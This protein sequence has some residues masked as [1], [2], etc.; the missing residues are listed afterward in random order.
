MVTEEEV[1][2]YL[3]QAYYISR[4]IRS[5]QDKCAELRAKALQQTSQWS[6][7]PSGGHSTTSP[8]AVWI[9]KLV[10]LELEIQNKTA[11]LIQAERDAFSLINLLSDHREKAV[12]E[13][14]H[15]NRLN[16]AKLSMKYDYSE[17][18]ILR[19]KN[20]GYRHLAKLI[21]EDASLENKIRMTLIPQAKR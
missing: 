20:K 18:Q 19:I 9:E 1:R 3:S 12:L 11:N 15:V 13:D 6:D 2:E 10:L 14:F 17:S 5:Q 16:N 4:R 8:Q 7:T 21:N